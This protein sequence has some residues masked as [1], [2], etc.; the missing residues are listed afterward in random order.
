MKPLARP[1]WAGKTVVCIASGPSLTQE[2]CE[3]VRGNVVIVTNTTFRLVPWADVLFAMDQKWWTEYHREVAETFKGRKVSV[4]QGAKRFGAETTYGAAWFRGFGNSGSGAL[5]FAI[6][7]NPARVLMLGFDCQATGGKTHWHG[8][9]PK[10]LSNAR[11]LPRWP[12]AFQSAAAHARGKGVKVLNCSRE[13]ALTCFERV[14][15]EVA[16]G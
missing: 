7:G 10:S 8:D 1:N 4:V 16:L 14:P 15:L 3:A 11:S 5:A 9:H 2:D 6:A 13:T 12:R